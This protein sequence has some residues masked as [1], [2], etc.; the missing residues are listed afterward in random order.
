MFHTEDEANGHK[1]L[2]RVPGDAGD[3]VAVGAGTLV[4]V[5]VGVEVGGTAATVAVR[6]GVGVAVAGAGGAVDV[7]AG[8]PG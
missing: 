1:Y 8:A 6:V 7:G 2:S 3:C 5:R 4:G